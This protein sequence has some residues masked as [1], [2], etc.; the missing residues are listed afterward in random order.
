[1]QATVACLDELPMLPENREVCTL[2]T[3][4]THNSQQVVL[5]S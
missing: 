2:Y 5:A 1:M 3:I 4:A